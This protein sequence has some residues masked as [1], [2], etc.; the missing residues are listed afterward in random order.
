MKNLMRMIIL[1]FGHVTIN[2]SRMQLDLKYKYFH[3]NL[4]IYISKKQIG[5]E[6]RSKQ[7]ER[8]PYQLPDTDTDREVQT[9]ILTNMSISNNY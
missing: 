7:G 9:R 8:C 5:K 6:V 4:T 2:L 3:S 1:N